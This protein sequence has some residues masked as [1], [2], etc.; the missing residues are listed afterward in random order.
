MGESE[1]VFL[2]CLNVINKEIIWHECNRDEF[3]EE[4]FLT[5]ENLSGKS[6][7]EIYQ[8]GFIMGLKQ[9]RYVI[10]EMKNSE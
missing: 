8:D 9:A 4:L 2:E 1:S 10:K 5:H 6:I 3:D 7:P